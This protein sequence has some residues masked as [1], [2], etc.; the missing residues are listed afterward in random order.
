[1]K[2]IGNRVYQSNGPFQIIFKDQVTLENDR[3]YFQVD[4]EFF[5]ASLPHHAEIRK[6]FEVTV[7]HKNKEWRNFKRKL[8]VPKIFRKPKPKN[9]PGEVDVEIVNY[10][11]PPQSTDYYGNPTEFGH[12]LV[13]SASF[14][15]TGLEIDSTSPTTF[16]TSPKPR[17]PADKHNGLKDSFYY[18]SSDVQNGG[19]NDVFFEDD[20][21]NGGELPMDDESYFEYSYNEATSD[22]PYLPQQQRYDDQQMYYR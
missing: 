18:I 11:R 9:K 19:R 16:P 1:M 12:D 17:N 3:V 20:A 14:Y 2:R 6:A 8:K 10:N 7:L 4:G 15:R 21:F 13:Y 5:I 22:Y